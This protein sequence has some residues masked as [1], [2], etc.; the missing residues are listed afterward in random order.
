MVHKIIGVNSKKEKTMNQLILL[1]TSDPK[2]NRIPV[3]GVIGGLYYPITGVVFNAKAVKIKGDVYPNQEICEM[4]STF[5]Q[6]TSAKLGVC[7]SDTLIGIHQSSHRP[8]Y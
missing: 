5:N 6:W 8:T 1:K 4:E 2:G 7:F 3:S